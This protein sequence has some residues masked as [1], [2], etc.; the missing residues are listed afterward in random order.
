MV[1]FVCALLLIAAVVALVQGQSVNDGLMLDDYNHRAELREAGWSWRGLAEA[2]HLGDPRRRVTMWWQQEADLYFF[3]PV[4]FAIMRAE[5][6]LGG[7]RPTVMHACSLAW[8]VIGAGLLMRLVQRLG[9][10]LG[11]A[12][13][14]GLLFVLHPANAFTVRWIACQNEQMSAAFILAAILCYGNYSGWW[15][16]DGSSTRRRFWFVGAIL[17]FVAA[18]GCRESS[19]MW[20]PVVV[21][22]DLLLRPARWKKR[23]GGYLLMGAIFCLYFAVRYVAI[24]GLSLPGRPYAWPMD[25]PG[26]VR[27]VIDKLAYYVLGLYAYFPI[28]GFS[29][30]EGLRQQP[31][32]F[33]GSVAMVAAIWTGLCL[34]LKDHRRR[35]LWLIGFSLLPLLPVLPVFASAHHLYTSTLALA[36]LLTLAMR[37]IYVRAVAAGRN[38]M[39]TARVATTLVIAFHLSLFVGYNYLYAVGMSGFSA[40]S[41]LPVQEVARYDRSLQPGDKLFFINLSPLGFNCLPGIEEAAG[42]SPLRGYLLTFTP[43]LLGMDQPGCVR[44]EG[45]YRLRVSIEDDAWFSGIMGRSMLK[46][47]GRDRPFE[48]GEMFYTPEFTAQII[49]GSEQG[50]SEILF[51]FNKPLDHPSYHFYLGS[52]HFAAYPLRFG[53]SFTREFR[54]RTE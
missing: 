42:V 11:W 1:R 38:K 46:A 9:G 31:A 5:Y 8:A 2:A 13:L 49:R 18:L 39:W 48:V 41:R 24:G 44:K 14:A 52:P 36:A 27:F 34:W 53:R 54:G 43:G 40:A 30:I 16:G 12:I 45:L 21:L 19:V 29:G 23:W 7:W 10:G 26:F 6:V 3:R 25:E 20:L 4:A 32:F 47:V 28:V 35:L 15:R 51:T 50:I 33:Y 22:G 17:F 37:A